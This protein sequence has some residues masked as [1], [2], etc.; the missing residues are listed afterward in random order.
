[1][2]EYL[3]LGF[4]FCAVFVAAAPTEEERLLSKI[5]K[6]QT[7]EEAAVKKATIAREESLEETKDQ[8]NGLSKII[9][10]AQDI[11]VLDESAEENS[12]QNN[13]SEQ[14][15]IQDKDLPEQNEVKQEQKL[16]TKRD[17]IE[18]CIEKIKTQKW[19]A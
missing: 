11:K 15:N 1:M 12:A 14:K 18:W 10:P 9:K 17:S 16:Q 8:K 2:K 6:V 19:C 5:N 7:E 4:I 3:I 13:I